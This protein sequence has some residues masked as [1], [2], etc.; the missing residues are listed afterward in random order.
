VGLGLELLA[1]VG[2]VLTAFSPAY[3]AGLGYYLIRTAPAPIRSSFEPTVS[4]ADRQL[5]Q[6]GVVP[7]WVLVLLTLEALR[8]LVACRGV[9]ILWSVGR[10][11]GVR[12]M[13]LDLTPTGRPE[14]SRR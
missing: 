10:W 11:S 3:H 12:S 14:D 4:S 7:D 13:V 8:S 2:V 6:F 1:S 5:D 9:N